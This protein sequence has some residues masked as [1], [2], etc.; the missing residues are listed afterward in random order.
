MAEIVLRTVLLNNFKR[1]RLN[2]ILAEGDFGVWTLFKN[3]SQFEE[4]LSTSDKIIRLP[5]LVYSIQL[6]SKI[7]LWH[8]RHEICH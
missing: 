3:V 6:A 8:Y 2:A 4:A 1:I 5:E 7:K